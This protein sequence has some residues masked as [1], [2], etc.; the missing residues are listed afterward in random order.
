MTERPANTVRLTRRLGFQI[1]LVMA[2]VLLP[3][4]I[5]SVT[6]SLSIV[7]EVDRRSEHALAGETLSAASRAASLIQTARGVASGL[8]ATLDPVLADDRRCSDEMRSVAAQHPDYSL[9]AFVPLSGKMTCSSQG[10]AFDFS[11]LSLFAEVV[12]ARRPYFVVN[13]QGPISE[14]AVLGI[15]QPVFDQAGAYIGFVSVSIPQSRLLPRP[16]DQSA[17]DQ[18]AFDIVTFSS[19]GKLLTASTSIDLAEAALP[20]SP[21][22]AELAAGGSTAFTA[23]SRSG[24]RRVFSA[25]P[26]VEGELYALGTWPAQGRQSPLHLDRV[27]PIILPLLVWAASLVAAWLAVEWL[28]LR[29][30][31]Q[32]HLSMTRFGRGVRRIA[33]LPLDGAPQ[34]LREMAESYAQ[35]T[36]TIVRNEAELEDTVH[37]KEVLLRELHHRVKNNLQLIASIMNMQMRRVGTDEARE[38]LRTVQDRVINLATIHRELFQTSGVMNVHVA[39]LFRSIILQIRANSPIPESEVEMRSEVENLCMAPDRAAPL[40]LFLAEALTSTL[41]QTLRNVGRSPWIRI[42]LRQLDGEQ[43]RL[44]VCRSSGDGSGGVA[45]AP[46]GDDLGRQ[47]MEAFALQL[48]GAFFCDARDG[49]VCIGVDFRHHQPP[50]GAD[51][52]VPA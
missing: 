45:G 52:P 38:V 47:L 30:L 24:E 12:A 25:A 1:A 35:M 49:A 48:G 27:T 50:E 46:Q 51:G 32:V 29:H 17:P 13:P 33:E 36:E 18:P 21:S 44:E 9:V 2:I 41:R 10:V 39:E 14:A 40:A 5:V 37:Q 16:A 23:L 11:G 31:R 22:L 42:S 7:S 34:E 20:A 43:A 4:T 19:S 26:L 8:A 6:R 3:L 28:V 15:S